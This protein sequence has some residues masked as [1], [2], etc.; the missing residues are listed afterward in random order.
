MLGRHK[1]PAHIFWFG[2]EGVENE[3]P[4]TGSGKVKKHVLRD[5]AVRVVLEREKRGKSLRNVM[6][7]REEERARL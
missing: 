2:E 4:Q 6:L 3:V 1:A 7:Q 5:W